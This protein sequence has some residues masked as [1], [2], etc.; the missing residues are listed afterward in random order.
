MKTRK[1]NPECVCNM[2]DDVKKSLAKG[3]NIGLSA[4]NYGL[5]TGKE[6]TSALGEILGPSVTIT[7][8]DFMGYIHF[9]RT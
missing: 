1:P 4:F 7:T 2:A 6:V 3:T 8:H 5:T 9:T